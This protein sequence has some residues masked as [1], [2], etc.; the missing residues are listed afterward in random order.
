M[1]DQPLILK[2]ENSA[3]TSR[4]RFSS[5]VSD[6][7]FLIALTFFFLALFGVGGVLV[8]RYAANQKIEALDAKRFKLQGDLRPHLIDQV[9][10][11]SRRIEAGR[12]LLGR[13]IFPSNVFEFLESATLPQVRFTSFGYAFDAK[14]VDVNAEAAS[15]ATLARQIR[16]LEAR[17]E[18]AK[19]EFGGLSLGEKG[20]V[21]FKISLIFHEDLF[22]RRPQSPPSVAPGASVAP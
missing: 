15:Y 17:K 19:V 12:S 2:T 20:L 5:R 6:A 4:M 10:E 18:I 22:F 16:T 1:V 9:V 3:R 14:R 8:F 7:F 13:H 21:H 11:L